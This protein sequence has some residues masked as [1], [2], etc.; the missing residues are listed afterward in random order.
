VAICGAAAVPPELIRR[1]VDR[2]GLDRMINAY[3]LM[4][5]T[6]VSMTRPGD[7][8]EV[9]ASSTGRAVPGVTL[10]I[11]DDDGKDLPPGERGEILVGGYGVM[12]GYWRDP[13]KTA[14]AVDAG[15]WLHTGDIGMIDDAGNLAIVDRKKE[16]FIVSGFNAYPAEIEGLLLQ[17]P[18]I[19][20]VAVIGVPDKRRGEVGQA[21]VVPAPGSGATP[22]RI[23]EWARGNMS[24]Y[25]VPHRVVLVD[26]LP[27]NPNGKID[28]PALHTRAAADTEPQ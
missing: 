6:V 18:D 24:N 9:I 8:V 28:K 1:L 21:Y 22:E 15:G 16:M 19:A 7:P 25:K 4:E 5:G 20:Q 23:I 26:A 27:V 11:V 2:V 3:G 10:R 14:E 17:C 12:R 13:E